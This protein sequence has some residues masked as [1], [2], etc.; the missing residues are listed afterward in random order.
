MAKHSAFRSPNHCLYKGDS[1]ELLRQL[2]SRSID[3]V[4]TDPPYH[5]TKKANIYGD[6]SFGDN[7]E[8]LSWM[9]QYFTEWHRV[10]RPNGTLYLFCSSEM[11][12]FLYVPLLAQ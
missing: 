11:S 12:P 9:D 3:L 6:A 4:L 5:S 1:L 2:P 8:Y 7:D 10:L